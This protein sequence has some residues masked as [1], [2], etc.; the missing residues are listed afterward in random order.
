[1]QHRK[2]N[3]ALTGLLLATSFTASA[4]I[5][6]QNLGTAAP[7]A[8]VGGHNM[9]PF[10]VTPQAAIPDFTVGISAIPGN[11]V[12]GTL[13]ISPT[14]DKR[15]VG[16]SWWAGSPTAWGHGYSG[17]VFYVT[18]KPVVLTLPANTHAFYFYMQPDQGGTFNVTAT[19]NSGAT[20]GAVPVTSSPTGTA[21][22]FAF[23]GTEGET[24]TSISITHDAPF[25]PGMAVA[26]FGISTGVATTCASEGYTGTQLRWCQIICESESSSSTVDTYLRR[27]INRY[28]DLPYCAVEDEGGEE[29]P[30]Q[31]EG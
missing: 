10:D 1:M 18:A 16:I 11:P 21:N 8:T 20:S 7:P 19:T 26:E 5:L 14:A 3:I 27:W 24:I 31:Q 25:Y 30:P 6:F 15:T 4:D 22:G 13:G 23:Y 2:L 9:T 29:E 28:H 17:P 12:A